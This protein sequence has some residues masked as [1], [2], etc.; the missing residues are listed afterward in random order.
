MMLI[1]VKPIGAGELAEPVGLPIPI[2]HLVQPEGTS[3]LSK[4]EA[5][6]AKFRKSLV[7]LPVFPVHAHSARLPLLRKYVFSEAPG[8]VPS[9]Y[10]WRK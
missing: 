4:H 1:W 6:I 2:V 5:I 9:P 10:L 3:G 8:R 7:K